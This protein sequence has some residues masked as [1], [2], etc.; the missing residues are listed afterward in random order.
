M[1]GL[2]ANYMGAAVGNGISDLGGTVLK[3]SAAKAD[4]EEKARE[5]DLDRAAR[6]RQDAAM[7]EIRRDQIAAKSGA[8]KSSGMTDD[9]MNELIAENTGM[10][11]PE[12]VAHRNAVKTGDNSAFKTVDTG[13]T[14]PA[15]PGIN[16]KDYP[17]GF[18]AVAAMKRQAIGRLMEQYTMRG[19]NKDLAEGRDTQQTVDLRS[20]L[21]GDKMNDAAAVSDAYAATDKSGRFSGTGDTVFNKSTGAATATPLGAAKIKDLGK[22]DPK[23]NV[24]VAALR[25]T[26]IDMAAKALGPAKDFR[27]YGAN[28]GTTYQQ[29]L[30]DLTDQ[31]YQQLLTDSQT[32]IPK[33]GTSPKMPAA[34]TASGNNGKDYS[35]LWK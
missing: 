29:K 6:E 16:L 1:S 32:A 7:N 2:V 11:V 5:K 28:K 21:I 10:S 30:N 15:N 9:Q 24:D 17:P 18:E 14:D 13:E 3:L 31:Y 26:A 23:D 8:G 4:A 12:V 35:R 27:P 33:P 25:A 34:P 19:D 22:Q 20:G